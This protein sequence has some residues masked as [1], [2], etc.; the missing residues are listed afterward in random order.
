MEK[1]V[2]LPVAKKSKGINSALEDS[3]SKLLEQV[4]S[5]P[6]ATLTDK[7]K[8]IDRVINVEK[9]KQKI[10]DDEWGSGLLVEND[11]GN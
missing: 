11:D 9:I 10:S 1:V 3:L 4:M 5:D 8:V 7:C 6:V 2:N